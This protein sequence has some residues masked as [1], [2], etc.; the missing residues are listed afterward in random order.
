[1]KVTA[2]R[3]AESKD[4]VGVFGGW[5]S[6]SS[7][8]VDT[9]DEC[10]IPTVC[11]YLEY[12]IFG[13]EFG[14]IWPKARLEGEDFSDEI[15][16]IENFSASAHEV[17]G[18]NHGWIRVPPTEFCGSIAENGLIHEKLNNEINCL[19]NTVLER[20]RS[21]QD[22]ASMITTSIMF[23]FASWTASAISI[24]LLILK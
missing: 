10:T 24:A 8:N 23:M 3:L 12:R 9:I 20:E 17:F 13:W 19:K 1:M 15:K 22:S 5:I 4:P 18:A 7:F 6:D 2:V 14:I 11:E 21:L 16:L